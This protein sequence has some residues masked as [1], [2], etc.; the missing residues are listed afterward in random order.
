MERM[1]ISVS[2]NVTVCNESLETVHPIKTYV[3]NH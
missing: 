2:I 3:T 1:R